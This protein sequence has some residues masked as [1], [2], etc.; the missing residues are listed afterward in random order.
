MGSGKTTV[1]RAVAA[2]LGLPFTD[3]D[4][5]LERKTGRTIAEVFESQGE[6]KF[7]EAESAAVPE[8]LAAGGVVA[9]GGGTPMDDAT[10]RLV[11]QAALTIFLDAEPDRLWERAAA[12][13][14]PLTRD[15]EQ[16]RQR[17]RARLPRYQEADRSV[18][19]NRPFEEVVAE[20][21][22]LCAG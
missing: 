15:R 11:R 21:L 7:R 6:A 18:D 10:W 3:L 17:Y 4:E 8:A 2:R 12:P 9:L 13:H 5:L 1:G 22:E 14:R 19:A 16:F 20:V